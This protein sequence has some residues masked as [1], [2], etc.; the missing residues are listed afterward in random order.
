MDTE[1]STEIEKNSFSEGQSDPQLVCKIIRFIGD[2]TTMES[3]TPLLVVPESGLP[4]SDNDVRGCPVTE[5]QATD[6]TM[7]KNNCDV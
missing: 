1:I 7:W 6:A 2:L 3:K 5:Y 4:Y